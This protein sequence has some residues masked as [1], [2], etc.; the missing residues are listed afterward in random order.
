M[1]GQDLSKYPDPSKDPKVLMDVSVDGSPLADAAD[2]LI[3]QS[4]R[5]ASLKAGVFHHLI[6]LPTYHDTALGTD[7][8]SEGYFGERACWPTSRVCSAARF[9]ASWRPSS[10]R[11]WPDPPLAMSTRPTFP[12][13]ML[14]R[15]EARP[16]P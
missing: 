11:I 14:F 7:V 5:E 10:I 4:Q 15:P 1:G 16:T 13:R 8:L 9:D 6:T 2:K 3:Q 12:R